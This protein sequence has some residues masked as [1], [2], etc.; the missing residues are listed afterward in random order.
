MTFNRLI[1]SLFVIAL[2]FLTASAQTEKAPQRITFTRGAIVARAT[3]FLRGI[4]DEAWFV[5]RAS[6]GQHARVEIKGRG[7]TRGV[8]VF[9]SGKQDGGPGGLIYDDNID[10]TGDYKIRVTESSMA[11]AWRGGFTVTIEMLPRGQSSQASDLEKYV[12]KYPT[13]LFRGVPA[14]KIRL[15]EL[16]GASYKLFFDRMQ[17]EIPIEKDGDTIVAR[18]C[19][20]HQCTIEEAILAIDPAG[21]LYV[22]LKFNSRFSKTVPGDRSRLPDALK[23]A[24]E[25]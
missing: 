8:L 18:G 25:H 13:D 6:A 21:K 2:V 19:M 7:A 20:A 10:E 3:G 12:G 11:N 17:V 5:L 16:L 4:R 15:R 24:M 22:A 9:P 1:S 14:L 23:R